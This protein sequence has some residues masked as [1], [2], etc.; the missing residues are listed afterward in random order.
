MSATTIEIQ[1]PAGTAFIEAAHIPNW[2][3]EALEPIPNALPRLC[4]LEKRKLIEADH[5]KVDSLTAQDWTLLDEIWRALPNVGGVD[6]EQF[7]SY[8]QAFDTASN[9][10]D[11]D[12]QASFQHLSQEAKIRQMNV[13]NRHFWD[14]EAAAKSGQI[15]LMTAQR[16][17]TNRIEPGSLVRV[18]DANRYLVPRGF[19]LREVEL[20]QANPPAE[21]SQPSAEAA[22]LHIGANCKTAFNAYVARRAREIYKAGEA[23]NRRAIAGI[24]EAE[25]KTNGW[26]SERGQPS[27]ATIEKEIPAGLTGGRKRNGRKPQAS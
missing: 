6:T 26:R 14:L 24:I 27:V 2:I 12:L 11:W 21:A 17:P 4:N 10:P 7:K 23:V 16:T 13:R 3:A 22:P 1:I 9:K 5:W 8:R 15:S 18:E 20:A 25:M 19:V